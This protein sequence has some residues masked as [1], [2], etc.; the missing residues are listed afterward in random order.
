MA[1]ERHVL[2][3]PFRFAGWDLIICILGIVG[4][5]A[6][7]WLLPHVHPD[8]TAAYDITEEE[9]I[10]SA[11]VFLASQGYETGD[12]LP[13]AELTRRE[14]LL[15]GLQHVLGRNTAVDFLYSENRN[16]VPAYYWL[17]RYRPQLASGE[18]RLISEQGSVLEVELAQDGNPLAL[19]NLNNRTGDPSTRD[20]SRQPR[21]NRAALTQAIGAEGEEERF[22]SVLTQLADSVLS[23][24]LSFDLSRQDSTGSLDLLY[25]LLNGGGSRLDSTALI[26]L[27]TYHLDGS[28]FS[29]LDMRADSVRIT[30]GSE[31]R[32]AW[33]GFETE[34]PLAG[35]RIRVEVTVSASGALIRMAPSFEAAQPITDTFSRAL[36][37]IKVG[38]YILLALG[39]IVVFLRRLS[40]RLLDLKAAL[41]DAMI[42]GVL[43]GVVAATST[44]FLADIFSYAPLWAEFLF[45]LIVFSIVSG[46][47]SIFVFMLAGVTDSV[48]RERHEGKLGALVLLRHGDFQ[49]K[50]VGSVLVRGVAL[51]GILMGLGVGSLALFE[52]LHLDL[53]PHFISNATFRPV[54]S[55]VFGGLETAYFLTLLWVVGVSSVVQHLSERPVVSVFLL[56]LTGAFLGTGPVTFETQSL[57]LLCGGLSAMVMALAWVRYDIVTVLTALFASEVLWKLSEGYLVG[58]S[59]AWIDA[60]LG[61]LFLTSLLVLGF[62]GLSSR[63]SGVE[64]STYIPEYVSQMASEERVRRELEIAHQVQS[65]FLPRTMPQ[66]NGLDIAG[67]CLSANEVGGDYYD[68]IERDDGR[69]AFILGDVSGKGIQAAFFMTLVKGIVQTLTRLNLSPAEVLRR[70]N[71]LFYR[72][73]PSGTFIS[74]VYG[75]IDPSTGTFTFARAGHN[76]VIW[77]RSKQRTSEALRPQGMA[78]GFTSGSRFDTTI[79]EQTI[80]MEPGDALVFYTD[81]FSEAM[82]RARSLYG[83]DR[84]VR[85]VTQTGE[86]P[87]ADILRLLTEDVHDYIGGVGRTDDMTMAVI[88]RQT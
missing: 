61:A 43:G 44:T 55:S 3:A 11:D 71:T 34:R 8:A 54:I 13:T 29:N 24:R 26:R 27:G 16:A 74:V 77:Y 30:N 83:D 65:F 52:H 62:V 39:F 40:G 75:E 17:V 33:I 84:L 19:R 4:L 56:T 6:L 42:I 25:A 68:F 22:L 14:Q 58:G 12:L 28:A 9:A 79:E 64:A 70:L 88:K 78:I 67:M 21:V 57:G 32:V 7:Y 35:Q 82:N 73:A 38:F 81:G 85:M 76:P 2:P 48:V 47:V 10:T 36:Q 63:R 18:S 5:A 37:A 46:A 1:K 23:K 51:C 50:L 72:N 41:V 53:G 59:P 66:V 69:M 80:V 20:R 86:R 45:R 15:S 49:N 87:S 60:L 31:S